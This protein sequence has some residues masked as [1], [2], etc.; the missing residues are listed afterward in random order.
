MGRKGEGGGEREALQSL[1]GWRAGSPASILR[2]LLSACC[3]SRGMVLAG[4][5]LVRSGSGRLADKARLQP[6]R[7]G[8]STHQEA[9][10]SRAALSI[11]SRRT[12]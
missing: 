4:C 7:P 11:F 6:V 10:E 9:L 12:S 5:T 8:T 1:S 2:L 3:M